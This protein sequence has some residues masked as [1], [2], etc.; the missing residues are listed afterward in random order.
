MSD[1]VQP[2][3]LRRS[4][5]NK[6]S[7]M[8]RL[9]VPA[10]GA[11]IDLVTEI[12]SQQKTET[13][14]I[15][16]V[17]RIGDER[18]GAIRLAHPSELSLIRRA[19]ALLGMFPVGYYDLGPAGIPVH[20]TAFRPIAPES[21]ARNSFRLFT[22]LVRLDEIGSPALR[23]DAEALVAKRR[24]VSPKTLSYVELAER[25]GGLTAQEGEAFIS[26]LLDT[27]RWRGEALC[28][29]D[30]YDAILD[31]HPL[32]ADVVCFPNPHINHLTP[33][34]LDIDAAQAAMIKK[35]LP[36]K[37]KIEGPPARKCP[38]LLRQTAFR[39]LEEVVRFPGDGSS[40][41][42][43]THTARFGEI[44]ARGCALTPK[45]MTL[46]STALHERKMQ[47]IPDNWESL[48]IQE[49]GWFEFKRAD[50]ELYLSEDRLEEHISSGEIVSSPITY[51]DFL[52]VSAAG[53][54]RSN[55]KNDGT[56]AVSTNGSRIEF[57]RALGS[58]VIDFQELYRLQSLN[59]LRA[60]VARP[61]VE[62][63]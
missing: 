48:R 24:I 51:E 1:F 6:L 20:S 61:A 7:N 31:V 26:S 36:A 40:S 15:S 4:F 39:A 32:L 50:P 60:T 23:G 2:W 9:E 37:E 18:H 29:R 54:F 3:T 14:K 56:N 63:S 27:F 8:Y 43:S 53:I 28:S 13:Q 10:Y 42:K 57:E 41:E 38:I 47:I 30:H 19:L 25:Q 49:L 62:G 55:L 45:G 44:E 5:A 52:P 12:N 58:P 33:R 16:D 21:L 46:Y 35:G 11:L 34:V 22:S 59:S 17:P